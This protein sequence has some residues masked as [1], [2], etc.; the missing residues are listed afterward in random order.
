MGG[1]MAGNGHDR[2]ARDTDES[3]WIH[4]NTL[5]SLNAVYPFVI[6]DQAFALEQD[7]QPP[8]AETG[9]HGRVGLES[10]QHGH[11]GR[12]GAALI[13]SGRR[14][15][16]GHATRPSQTRAARLQ[17]PHLAPSDGAHHFLRRPR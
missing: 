17:P 12:A 15:D 2:D 8:I 11:V 16:A 7:V 4:A 3:H 14:A 5:L 13:A 10:R 1:F 9:A 6:H